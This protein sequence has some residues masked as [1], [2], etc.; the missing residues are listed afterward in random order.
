MTRMPQQEGGHYHLH[1]SYKFQGCFYVEDG[2]VLSH[3]Y[4]LAIT[5]KA[6][7]AITFEVRIMNAITII[8][9]ETTKTIKGNF[10]KVI[11]VH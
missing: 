4:T 3:Q 7:I 10:D 9:R 5:E 11:I 8:H 2:T 6:N 1:I